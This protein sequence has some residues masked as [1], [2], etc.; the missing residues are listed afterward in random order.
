MDG[1]KNPT[2]IIGNFGAKP[3]VFLH[4]EQVYGKQ[5]LYPA[6]PKSKLFCEMCGFKTFT[7][8][9]VD[10][11]KALGYNIIVK[12]DIQAKQQYKVD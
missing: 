3:D 8:L 11:V 10:K 1:M 2:P 5:A 6:C 4:P 7:P 12:W 9:M